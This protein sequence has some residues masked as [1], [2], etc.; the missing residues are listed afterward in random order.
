MLSTIRRTP[1]SWL[2]HIMMAENVLNIVPK[3]THHH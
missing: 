1:L 2:T 3:G